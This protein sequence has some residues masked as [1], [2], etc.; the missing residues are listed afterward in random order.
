MSGSYLEGILS[1]L[2]NAIIAM[3]P[4]SVKALASTLVQMVQMQARIVRH[5]FRKTPAL[6]QAF[7]DCFLP[8]YGIH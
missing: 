5:G 6:S 1:M 2:D 8:R 4:M 3:F 7:P